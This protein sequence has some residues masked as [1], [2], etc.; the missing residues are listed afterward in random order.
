MEKKSLIVTMNTIITAN[1][2]TLTEIASFQIR[3]LMEVSI[4]AE[5]ERET[6]AKAACGQATHDQIKLIKL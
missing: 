5:E 4:Y 6:I 1:R 3:N 2:A